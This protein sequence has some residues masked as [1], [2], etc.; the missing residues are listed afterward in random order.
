[1]FTTNIA[2]QAVRLTK[3]LIIFASRLIFRVRSHTVIDEPQANVI[4]PD[5]TSTTNTEEQ[6]HTKQERLVID[7]GDHRD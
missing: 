7:I 3:Q 4:C 6:V 5:S 1:M 2:W